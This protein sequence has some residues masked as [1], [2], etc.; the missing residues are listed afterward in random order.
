MKRHLIII[1]STFILTVIVGIVYTIYLFYTVEESTTIGVPFAFIVFTGLALFVESFLFLFVFLK[2]IKETWILLIPVLAITAIIPLYFANNWYEHLPVEIP[3]SGPVPVSETVYKEH[4]IEIIGNYWDL[5]TD[6]NRVTNTR[7]TIQNVLI[8][9]II[10]SNDLKKYFAII[11]AVANDGQGLKYCANY[12]VGR[13]RTAKWEM[14]KPKG[15]IWSNCFQSKKIL[16]SDLRQYFYKKYSI[17]NSSDKQE[18][19]NDNYIFNFEEK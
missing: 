12:R 15:N 10:Y 6:S 2:H 1:I 19:W 16:K 14:G 4:T 3:Q 7:D 5:E 8:D 9:T 11:I 18:I 17:N 13:Q